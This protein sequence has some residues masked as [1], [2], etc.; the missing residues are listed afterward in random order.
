M[1]SP[2]SVFS[3]STRTPTSMLVAPTSFTEAMEHDFGAP[4]AVA[5][6]FE[7]VRAGHTAVDNDDLVAASSIAATIDELTNVLGLV[8]GAANGG[9]DDSEIDDLVAQRQA[10]RDSKDFAESDRLRDELNARSIEVE[11]TAAGPIWR[12]V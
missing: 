5:T 11:D 1:L 10:A 12:R 8:T 9:D 6:I 3:A 7:L 2:V 4:A